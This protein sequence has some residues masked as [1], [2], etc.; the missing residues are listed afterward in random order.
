[1]GIELPS[2]TLGE[3]TCCARRTALVPE[4]DARKIISESE[5]NKD[6]L[7]PSL[8]VDVCHHRRI[9]GDSPARHHTHP[10]APRTAM[11]LWNPPFEDDS[12]VGH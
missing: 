4:P 7:R 6:S 5:F 2:Q 12:I 8:L 9:R 10:N 3:S 11:N 1:M